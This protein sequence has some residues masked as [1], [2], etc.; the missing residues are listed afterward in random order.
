MMRQIIPLIHP[1]P[2]SPQDPSEAQ[3]Q[4]SAEAL[5]PS[6]LRTAWFEPL[7]AASN[8]GRPLRLGYYACDGFVQSSPAVVRS[9]DETVAALQQ[10]HGDSIQMVPIDPAAIQAKKAL[11][12]FLAAVG[13]DGFD[14]LL[15]PLRQGKV[16]EPMDS[17]LFV[18]VLLARMPGWA[19]KL[20]YWIMKY[21][22]R[23]HT[24]SYC[25]TAAGRKT[26]AQHFQT[27]AQRN[28][29]EREFDAKVW[30]EY[31][32]DAILCPVQGSPAVPH[33]AT[34]KL[35]TLAVSTIIYNVLDTAVTVLP[36]TR[37]DPELDALPPNKAGSSLTKAQQSYLSTPGFST[38]SKMVSHALYTEKVYDPVAMR[39]LPV[40]VQ[41][42]TRKFEEE[43]AIG[44]MRLVDDALREAKGDGQK[45]GW[46]PGACA[47][48]QLARGNDAKAAARKD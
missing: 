25:A 14:G 32:V 35:S 29:Y 17:S 10:A 19:R 5:R 2:D 6:P 7:K 16:K 27:V 33:G 28:E 38:C 11:R 8:R 20:V 23:D 46:G 21:V 13:S 42:V 18:P 48:R 15:S 12:T 1:S 45:Y 3:N 4:F 39:G 41:V 44:I 34:A 22:V 37:V 31:G 9:I 30:K 47:R 36:V 26:A 24:L 40:S 43:K